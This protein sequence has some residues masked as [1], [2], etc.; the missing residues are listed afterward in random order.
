MD[1]R[2][3]VSDDVESVLPLIN[4]LLRELGGEAIPSDIAG[5]TFLR[6]MS[7]K[8]AGLILVVEEQGRIAG[9]CTVSFQDAIRSRGRYGIIQEMYVLPEFRSLGFGSKLVYEAVAEARSLGCSML[10]VG[11]PVNDPRQEGFYKRAGFV[12]VGPR[13]RRPLENV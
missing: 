7:D 3:A 10:E 2:R 9:V 12:P 1:I 13:L 6:L 11:A 8:D 5:Q 4:R